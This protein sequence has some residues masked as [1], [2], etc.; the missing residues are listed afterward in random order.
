MYSRKKVIRESERKAVLKMVTNHMRYGCYAEE[1]LYDDV[2]D[3]LLCD[4]EESERK[5]LGKNGL[6]QKLLDEVYDEA[7]F[8]VEAENV[9][10]ADYQRELQE[11]RAGRW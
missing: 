4:F 1:E 5:V 6:A 3:L 10:A 11:A 2:A 9:E 7:R 8:T